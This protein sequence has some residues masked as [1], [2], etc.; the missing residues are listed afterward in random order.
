M[1]VSLTPEL[2]ALVRDKV[3]S[4]LY[5]TSDEVVREAL[6]LLLAQERANDLK[7]MH[8]RTAIAEGDASGPAVELDLEALLEQLD[9]EA[10]RAGIP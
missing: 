2:E 4:G 5:A 3:A 10:V 1:Q 9:E 8:L 7:L 6:R